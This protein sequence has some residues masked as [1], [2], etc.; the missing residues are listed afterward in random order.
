MVYEFL[1]DYWQIQSEKDTLTPVVKNER[2]SYPT[3]PIL[4][5]KG[6]IYIYCFIYKSYVYIMYYNLQQ[7]IRQ[8]IKKV[9]FWNNIYIIYIYHRNLKSYQ[10]I[11]INDNIHKYPLYSIKKYLNRYLLFK[12][13]VCLML[14]VKFPPMNKIT[15]S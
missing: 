6:N 4:T 11:N 2:R 3:R 9:K 15:K 1:Y 13:I 7:H 12:S 14:T 5:W 8:I 10:I